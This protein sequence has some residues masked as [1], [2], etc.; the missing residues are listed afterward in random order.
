MKTFKLKF[1]LLK[2]LCSGN[3]KIVPMT[4]MLPLMTFKKNLIFYNF[5]SFL[6]KKYLQRSNLFIQF[7]TTFFDKLNFD[8]FRFL[9]LSIKIEY[10]TVVLSFSFPLALR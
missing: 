1:F 3:C 8:M 6:F 5:L 2:H 10:F 4:F 9:E 7:C